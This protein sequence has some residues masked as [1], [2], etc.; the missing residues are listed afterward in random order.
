VKA[1]GGWGSERARPPIAVLFSG[2]VC[3][4]SALRT[5]AGQTVGSAGKTGQVGAACVTAGFV[6]SFV[7]FPDRVSL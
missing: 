6:F 1:P 4:Q 3:V 5:F 7:V 2:E